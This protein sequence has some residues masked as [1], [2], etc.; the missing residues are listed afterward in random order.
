ML[1][2][3]LARDD[4]HVI[5]HGAFFALLVVY[6]LPAA[7]QGFPIKIYSDLGCLRR[8]LAACRPHEQRRGCAKCKSLLKGRWRKK[9]TRTRLPRT[10][11][12]T[13]QSRDRLTAKRELKIQTQPARPAKRVRTPCERA[14]IPA[15][16]TRM[17]RWLAGL[18]NGLKSCVRAQSSVASSPRAAS[19]HQGDT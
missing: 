1:H 15:R 7:P 14:L 3:H 6:A 17:T 10:G 11:S 16:R 9:L 4:L 8:P 2:V 13:K 18:R 12:G 5:H 19:P